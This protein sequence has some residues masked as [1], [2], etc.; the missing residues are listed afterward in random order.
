MTG[1]YLGM[2]QITMMKFDSKTIRNF[3]QAIAS[4]FYKFQKILKTSYDTDLQISRL[5]L[6][7]SLIV[8]GSTSLQSILFSK[9]YVEID[10]CF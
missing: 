6:F 5:K 4:G 7:H 10:H 9:T 3:K 1:V 2:R 8:Y